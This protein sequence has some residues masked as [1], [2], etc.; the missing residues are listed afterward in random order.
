MSRIMDKAGDFTTL[1]INPDKVEL[2]EDGR[3]DS[4][5]AGHGEVWYFDCNFDDGSTLVLGFRPKSV[6][7]VD[8]DGDKSNVAINYTAA[9]GTSFYDYRLFSPDE[10]TTSTERCDIRYGPHTLTGDWQTY[11]ARI[12]PEPDRDIVMEGKHSTQHETTIDLHFEAQVEP[13]R[14]GTGYIALD[15][16]ESF[17]Y[18]FIC[19]TKLTVSG[20]V[21]INGEDKDVTGSAYYNHQWFNTVGPRAFH[22]WLWGRQN[23]GDYSVLIYDMVA[24]ERWGLDQIPLFTIDDA[25][26][27]RVFENTEAIGVTTT[28]LDSYVQDRTGK[29]YPKTIRY[30]FAGDDTEVSFTISEPRE[31]NV[32]DLY[33]LASAEQQEQYDAQGVQPTYTRYLAEA[34]L[35]INDANNTRT[36]SGPMLYEFNYPGTDNPDAHLY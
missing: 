13:F 12:S 16:D 10:V 21:V 5:A 4:D 11:D 24:A 1:G 27:T 19:I 2:W 20:H 15:D 3:R 32:I 30:D 9:D 7:Q 22:H 35:T 17:Y 8:R 26:G 36:S 6:D 28:V 34:E 33:G 18:N 25:K 31:I 29:R 23:I 14:P